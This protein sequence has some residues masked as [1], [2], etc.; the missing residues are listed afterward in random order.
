M[1]MMIDDPASSGLNG[2]SFRVAMDTAAIFS[3]TTRRNALRL[4]SGLPPLDVR[5]E[6]DHAVAVAAQRDY[7]ARCEEFAPARETIRQ[8]VLAEL[9]QKHGAS[10]GHSMGGR[11]AVGELTRKRFEAA[12]AAKLG[13]AP[14]HRAATRNAI[15][16]GQHGKDTT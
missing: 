16:Y 3:D 11:W 12:M 15:I 8:Q 14:E 10:F 5:T 7:Q 6:Y 2:A 4:A 9:Q 1:M 13:A